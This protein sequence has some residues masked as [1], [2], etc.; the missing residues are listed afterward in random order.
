MVLVGGLQVPG[1][2]PSR[3][4]WNLQPP[5]AFLSW[6]ER[7]CST[8]CSGHGELPHHS[9]QKQHGHQSWTAASKTV[10]RTESFPFISWFFWGI[11]YSNG[12]LTHIS[13]IQ[14]VRGSLSGSCLEQGHWVERDGGRGGC[15][16]ESPCALASPLWWSDTCTVI[17]VSPYWR[18]R[19]TAECKQLHWVWFSRWFLI[20][21]CSVWGWV[22]E[23]AQIWTCNT[24][25]L[26]RGVSQGPLC[27][28]VF[29]H[30]QPLWRLLFQ[31][32]LF[33]KR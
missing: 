4:L 10:S 26:S 6:H 15:S 33:Y 31:V 3:G 13:L 16:S 11:C 29:I 24:N 30:C 20:I 22:E 9:P 23:R 18:P 27:P 8:T 7:F 25:N 2:M 21:I 32:L 17:A 12:K 1:T 19:T 5:L 14:N 28:Q